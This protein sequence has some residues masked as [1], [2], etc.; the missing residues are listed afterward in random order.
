[1]YKK[2]LHPFKWGYIVNDNEN[3]TEN[4]KYIT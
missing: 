3:E 1:M 4:E 2:Q